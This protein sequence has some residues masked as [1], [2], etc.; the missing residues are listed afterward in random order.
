[1]KRLFSLLI[2]ASFFLPSM[3][4]AA[5]VEGS[6]VD[7]SG[8]AMPAVR[9]AAVNRLGVVRGTTTDAAGSFRLELPADFRGK[10]LVLAAGFET[11]SF[12]LE[13]N[14]E[15]LRVVMPLAP[16]ADSL[17]V[18]GSAFETPL[19]EQGSGIT[20]IPRAEID[21]R[22]EALALDLIREAPGVVINQTGPRGGLASLNVRGGNPDFNLVLVD[23]V[24]VN[25]FG[26]GNFDFAHIPSERLERVELI[27]GA[28]SAVYGSYANSSVVNFVTRLGDEVPRM[29]IT[30]E[31]GTFSTRR[32]A[33]G[34]GGILRGFQLSAFASRLDTDGPTANSD[35]RNQ[36]LSLTVRRHFQ[37]QSLTLGGNFISSGNGVP[38]PYGSNPAGLFTGLDLISRNNNNFSTYHAHYEADFSR[39]VRQEIFGSFFQNNNKFDSPWGPTFNKDVRGTAE[40]RTLVSLTEND[41]LAFGFAYSREQVKNSA[42]LDDT[43]AAFPLDRHHEG[44]YLE[45]RYRY[46]SRLFLTA[47]VRAEFIQTPRIPANAAFGRPEFP[48]HGLSRVNPKVAAGYVLRATRLHASFGTGI[49]PPSGFDLSFTDNPALKPERTRTFDAGI[50]QRLFGQRLSLDATYFYNR[51]YDLIVSLG[52]S[53][54]RLSAFQTDNLSNSRARGVEFSARLRPH[55]AVSLAGNYTWLDTE[56]LSLNGASGVAPHYF[57]VGQWLLRRPRHSGALTSTFIYKRMSANVIGY[58]RGEALDTEP[59][60][61][62]SAG[63]FR[64]PGHTNLGINLNLDVG[65][66]LTLYGNLRNALNQQYE[67]VFGFPSPRL[68]FITGIKWRATGKA[69]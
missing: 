7:P 15:P 21:L 51:F 1:M 44:V 36:N 32:F 56:I 28:Q 3:T 61:G 43:M 4:Q 11:R 26:L 40:A 35:Y 46:G 12:D 24:P 19:S 47:G 10:L 20:V 55:S 6:V 68:N 59:N 16:Q 37:R 17:T 69:R 13:A 9:V 33:I 65:R 27:R 54:A 60:F 23:G 42:I 48:A 58:F 18:T 14:A 67:E 45:N 63:L 38:G 30:A 8:A 41:T 29:D 57:Q 5:A 22:N 52:G 25:S 34:S 53:L 64:N 49:R 62:A 31:G 2:I 50:E 66:G 39:R